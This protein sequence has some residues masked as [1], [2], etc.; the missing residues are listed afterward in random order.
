MFQEMGHPDD[1]MGSLDEEIDLLLSSSPSQD[2]PLPRDGKGVGGR[3][4]GEEAK[5]NKGLFFFFFKL[6]SFCLLT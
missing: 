3:G 5:V 2:S 4:G 6:I 1:I